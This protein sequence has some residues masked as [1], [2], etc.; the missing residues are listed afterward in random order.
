MLQDARR[1]FLKPEG[2]M[3]PRR[4]RLSLG[5][6]H[7]T[8]AREQTDGWRAGGVPQ[9]FHWVR[10]LA[11]NKKHNNQLKPADVLSEVA[12]LGSID[13]ASDA[14]EFL[15]WQAELTVSRDGQVDSLAGWFA[16]E[17]AEDVWMTNSPLA[18]A[19]IDRPQA[20]LPIGEAVDVKAGEVIKATVMARPGEHMLAW[21]VEF[22]ASGRRFSHSSW[23][24]MILTGEDMMRVEPSRVP[25]LNA[26]GRARLT[27]LGYCDGKRT[28]REIQQA[29]L[30]DHPQLLP[31]ETEIANFVAQV[32]AKDTRS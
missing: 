4:L 7:S 21:V 20:I 8:K 24:G 10:E 29:V 23:Q 30:A 32:L 22:P 5:A 14:P 19:A 27:V 2:R 26:E 18:E 1:R 25:Q 13:L 31:S 17:L 11:I 3:I 9:A 15:R 12:A 6:A 28:A 16:C